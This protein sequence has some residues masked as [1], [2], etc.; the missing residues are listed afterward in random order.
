MTAPIPVT[1]PGATPPP[2]EG[3]RA[4]RW[5]TYLVLLPLPLWFVV[6]VLRDSG[7]VWRAEYYGNPELSGS[8]VVVKERRSTRYWDRQDPSVVGGF[9][10]SSFSLRWDTCLRLREARQIPF[11]LVAT[12]RASFAID[13]REQLRVDGGKERAARG[14]VLALEPG[15][16]HLRV[17]FS[18]RGWPAIGLNASFDGHAPVA[19]P[20]EHSG[21]GVT[22]FQP[23]PGPQLCPEK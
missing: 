23:R 1:A 8:P 17:E 21:A 5:V 6:A 4:V 7:P 14:A 15:T 13:D 22:W 19:L 18:G 9:D 2:R 20:P 3:R 12:G 11:Q 16:H 10:V